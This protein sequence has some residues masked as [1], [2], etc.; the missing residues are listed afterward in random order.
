MIRLY[1]TPKFVKNHFSN[2]IWNKHSENAI[3]LTF[4]DG[5]H[6]EITL[7]IME[8][9][10]QWQAKATFFVIGENVAKC[11]SLM[12][13]TY[14]AGHTIANHTYN[15]L[16]GW[17]TSANKYQKNI[18]LCDEII[19]TL[20]DSIPS[21]FR[22]PYGRIT[23]K[24]CSNLKQKDIVMWSHLA[25]DFDKKLSP[26]QSIKA[27]EKAKPGSIIVFHDSE[28]AEKNLKAI[29]PTLLKVYNDRGLQ[30]LPL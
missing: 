29:L 7:W 26:S 18:E 17:T 16:N 9:L 24:Q 5:P 12:R 23:S 27:L 20:S 10:Y 4:D 28:K 19:Y 22:P 6:P 11:S 3:F 13:D 2:L 14:K 25:W 1:K 15:H 30:M 8:Q 21:L